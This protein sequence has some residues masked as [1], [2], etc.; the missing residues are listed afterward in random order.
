MTQRY[1][2]ILYVLLATSAACLS[3][4]KFL[5][6]AKHLSVDELGEYS[7]IMTTYVFLI[8][9]GSLGANEYMLKMG[10]FS[11]A[12]G[13]KKES[14]RIRTNSLFYGVVQTLVISFLLVCLLYFYS[15]YYFSIFFMAALVAIPNLCFNILDS[16]F[17]S[18]RK[19][20]LFSF[21]MFSKAFLIMLYAYISYA[22][23]NLVVAI[24]AEFFSA[25]SIFL[26]IFFIKYKEFSIADIM[27]PISLWPIM[28][29]H[30]FYTTFVYMV[31]NLTVMFDRFFISFALGVSVLGQYAFV[32]I[33]YQACVLGGGML[34]NV[35]G[36][37]WLTEASSSGKV[38][39][40]FR[41]IMKFSGY[42]FF[43]GALFY[44]IFNGLSPFLIRYFFVQYDTPLVYK[45]M[46][47]VYISS[48]V[49]LCTSFLDWFYISTSKENIILLISLI[50]LMLLMIL[51]WSCWYL[52]LDIF[53]YVCSFLIVRIIGYL[54]MTAYSW[55][56]LKEKM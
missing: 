52:K 2:Y 14:I 38:V 56:I 50:S 21:M 40:I 11:Y 15:S 22:K 31:R 3:F 7:L 33:I 53:S 44:P 17:R 48:I 13:D 29:K 37:R 20:L 46:S 43:L 36:P 28:L 23:I 32:M 6:F 19:V 1:Q 12:N 30:G 45:I 16:F 25:I 41:K 4:F 42:V 51:F 34:T 47:I 27:S 5:F 35:L 39:Y 18:T 26:I 49:Y 10:S 54:L 55:I 24:Q 8:Y 9:I